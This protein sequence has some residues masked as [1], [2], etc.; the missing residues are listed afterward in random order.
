M[1]FVKH[2]SRGLMKR[3]AHYCHWHFVLALPYWMR[4]R[5]VPAFTGCERSPRS[6][7]SNDTEEF[8]RP[9]PP[10]SPKP[11]NQR[12]TEEAG[13]F[14]DRAEAAP[15]AER[16]RLIKLARQLDTAA[17]IEGWLSSPELK[18]PS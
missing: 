12:L 5:A 3:S 6:A 17:N 10:C 15:D 9:R 7:N 2:R 11:L 18:P 8:M 4:L 13:V 14:R 1:M 16:E